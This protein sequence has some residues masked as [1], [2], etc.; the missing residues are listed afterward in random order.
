MKDIKLNERL[1]DIEAELEPIEAGAQT[2]AMLAHTEAGEWKASAQDGLGAK[3]YLGAPG[4]SLK[5]LRNKTQEAMERNGIAG[6]AR[7]EN[8]TITITID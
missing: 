2:L 5:G 4:G 6:S 1:T 7:I 8:G 3:R